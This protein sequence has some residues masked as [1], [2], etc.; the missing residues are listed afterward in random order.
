VEHFAATLAPGERTFTIRYGGEMFHPPQDG[1]PEY[2]RKMGET[3]GLVS[4][5]GALLSGATRWVPEMSDDLVAFTLDVR[6]PAIGTTR[7]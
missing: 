7:C 2:A 4:P 3:P 5:E 6:S 1:G